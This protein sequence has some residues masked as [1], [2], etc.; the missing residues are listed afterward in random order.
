MYYFADPTDFGSLFA[1]EDWVAL[2]DV[3]DT[4]IAHD[5]AS[6]SQEVYTLKA[7]TVPLTL[8]YGSVTV[9][10]DT[11]SANATTS[12]VNTGN[13]LIDLDLGGD[14][15]KAGASSIAYDKQK[16]STSTFTYSGCAV[17][18][19]LAP[20]T[21]PTYFPIAVTKPTS[22]A[23]FFKNIYWGVEVPLGTSATTHSGTNYFTAQ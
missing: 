14:D 7:L 15:M 10:S 11:G 12:V 1:S 4:S 20:S 9:G 19:L 17:C 18:N 13:S 5:T 3:W 16:Y 22:T 8:G 6:S 21:T 23:S 2:I